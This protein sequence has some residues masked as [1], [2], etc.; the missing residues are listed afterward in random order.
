VALV[1]LRM[2]V[3][4]MVTVRCGRLRGVVLVHHVASV[5]NTAPTIYPM[6]VYGKDRRPLP[7]K[8]HRHRHARNESPR[9]YSVTV[10]S[11][12]TEVS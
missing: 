4:T 2:V 5:G 9:C 12:V 7:G 8:E 11:K 6:G 1:A 3:V 10:V